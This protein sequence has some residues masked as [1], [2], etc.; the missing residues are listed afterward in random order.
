MDASSPDFD[1]PFLSI[2][3]EGREMK[4][5]KRVEAQAPALIYHGPGVDFR[6]RSETVCIKLVVTA[7][8]ML[9]RWS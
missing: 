9:L 7:S 5:K 3:V 6:G 1:K 4:F 2:V 8:E